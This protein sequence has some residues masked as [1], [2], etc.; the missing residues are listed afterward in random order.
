MLTAGAGAHG[1]ATGAGDGDLVPGDQG[2]RGGAHGRCG[3]SGRGLGGGRGARA[4]RRQT[5]G[6]GEHQ[7]TGRGSSAS[8]QRILLL[9][10]LHDWSHIDAQN[11]ILGMQREGRKM[12]VRPSPRHGRPGS[13][14]RDA[15]SA[16]ITSCV[17]EGTHARRRAVHR[18][19]SRDHRRP[20]PRGAAH[21]T[22]H[23]SPAD[24]PQG[25][26]AALRTCSAPSARTPG[27]PAAVLRLRLQTHL[28]ARSFVNFNAA[29]STSPGS[30]SASTS[31]SDRTCNCSPPPTPSRRSHAGP[32]GSPP[33]RSPS[34]TTS[35][36]AV[37]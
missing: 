14:R 2:D 17:H 23:R 4:R 22:L 3:G 6:Q 25:R 18:E 13:Q 26:L 19:R 9:E 7:P 11:Y 12:T 20:G 29:C 37:G 28:G 1:G 10:R 27:T 34:A 24:D 16:T 30:P 33:S 15:R 35:G 32:S 5:E 36:S 8:V 21:R 31:R